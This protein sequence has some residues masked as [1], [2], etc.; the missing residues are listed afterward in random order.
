MLSPYRYLVAKKLP[1]TSPSV[2]IC[3]MTLITV[4]R[5]PITRPD[6]GSPVLC[7]PSSIQLLSVS[8]SC[9]K[10]VP[11]SSDQAEYLGSMIMRMFSSSCVVVLYC[12]ISQSES[13]PSGPFRSPPRP[14]VLPRQ[15]VH[16]PATLAEGTSKA[17]A[18]HLRS[19]LKIRSPSM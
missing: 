15:A 13:S 19:N 4:T 8:R 17:R 10:L 6:M 16:R 11:A 3:A 12:P 9:S 5:K 18:L 14:F 2:P 1:Q 7:F